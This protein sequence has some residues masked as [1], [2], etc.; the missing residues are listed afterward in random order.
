MDSQCFNYLWSSTNLFQKAYDTKMEVIINQEIAMS[1]LVLRNSRGTS[2]G[3][4]WNISC[5]IPEY[6]EGHYNEPNGYPKIFGDLI[7]PQN[8]LGRPLHPYEVIFLKTE[9]QVNIEAIESLTDHQLTIDDR[10]PPMGSAIRIAICFH[11]G[12]G[13]MWTQMAPYIRRVY[14]TG[15]LVDFYLSYQ[16]DTDPIHFIRQQYPHVKLIQTQRG[17]DTGAFLLQLEQIYQSHQPYDYIFKLH[18]KKRDDWRLDLL[19]PIA[20]SVEQVIAICDQ[21]R[22]HPQVGMIGGN[23]R[24]IIRHDKINVPLINEMARRFGLKIYHKSVFVAGTIF[25]VRWSLLKQFIEDSRINLHQEYEQCESG[26]L[27]NNHPTH[28]HSWERLF[29]YLIGHYGYQIVGGTPAP[30]QEQGVMGDVPPGGLKESGPPLITRLLYGL[31]EK[32][33]IDITVKCSGSVIHFHEI[34]TN[35]QWG[36]PYPN[37]K[38]H[39]WV[40]LNSGETVRFDENNAHLTPDN[41]IIRSN[42]LQLEPGDNGEQY[43]TLRSHPSL[44]WYRVTYFDW[45]YY[46]GKYASQIRQRSYQ[47]CLQHYLNNGLKNFTFE[48]GRDLIQKYK[49]KLIAYYLTAPCDGGQNPQS[50][51]HDSLRRQ[52]E[53]AH[54]HSIN[55]W[56]LQYGWVN[57]HPCFHQTVER[58][59]SI[60]GMDFCLTWITQGGPHP[61]SPRGAEPPFNPLSTDGGLRGDAVSLTMKEDWEQHFKFLLPFFQHPHYIKIKTCP[62]LLIHQST[63]QPPEMYQLWNQLACQAGFKGLFLT[64]VVTSQ[65]DGGSSTTPVPQGERTPPSPPMREGGEGRKSTPVPSS[66]QSGCPYQMELNPLY[67]AS[68]GLRSPWDYSDLGHRIVNDTTSPTF[69]SMFTGFDNTHNPLETRKVTCRRVTPRAVGALL[70]AL[71]EKILER[72]NEG[73]DHEHLIFIHSWNDWLNQMVLSQPCLEMIHQIMTYY[74]QPHSYNKWPDLHWGEAH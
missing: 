35:Q 74:R 24:W 10:L 23:P 21:F 6:Q 15:Y 14:Q 44:G 27:I 53:I 46:Y 59:C 11:L 58:L 49:I 60:N 33:A 34:N 20:K 66:P 16:K 36:D 50:E 65:N 7:Y 8:E 2:W 18:T 73:D 71:I 48:I 51:T 30:L 28:T 61:P 56:C 42:I 13:Q 55:A 17:C 57:S 29:G 63:Q 22:T 19:E 5:L 39:L 52:V 70:Q 31:S 38:K 4:P 1:Q 47:E 9:R 25:W 12:Y 64:S 43:I 32:D 3:T 68:G 54:Q 37:H 62:L 72:G 69:Y 41:Y 45:P 26:Y 40:Q 67:T